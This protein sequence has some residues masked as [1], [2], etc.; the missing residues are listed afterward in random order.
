MSVKL[1]GK[2]W[3]ATAADLNDLLLREK[4]VQVGII[5]NNNN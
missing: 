2:M 1:Y 3:I 4:V 5:I